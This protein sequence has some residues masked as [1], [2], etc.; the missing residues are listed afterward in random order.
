M[1][2]R[3]RPIPR[4]IHAEQRRGGQCRACCT[5]DR[6]GAKAATEKEDAAITDITTNAWSIYGPNKPNRTNFLGFLISPRPLLASASESENRRKM[7]RARRLFRAR[8]TDGWMKPP[9]FEIG[10]LVK[11]KI[12]DTWAQGRVVAHKYEEPK[13]VF[14]PS[15]SLSRLLARC[16]SLGFARVHTHTCACSFASTCSLALILA[17]SLSLACSLR[18]ARLLARC[19]P[20]ALACTLDAHPLSQQTE[21]LTCPGIKSSSRMGG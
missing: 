6:A 2:R 16:H 3:R 9:R 14:N 20:L 8:H 13:T 5:S 11:C 1:A 19:Q 12:D 10:T 4:V 18:L 17:R 7:G 15:L 21:P